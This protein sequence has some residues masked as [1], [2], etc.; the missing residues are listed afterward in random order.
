M[1]YKYS[2]NLTEAS[3]M[4]FAENEYQGV[5]QTGTMKRIPTTKVKEGIHNAQHDHVDFAT[6]PVADTR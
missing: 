2:Q 5:E 3:E 6:N 1:R 4:T